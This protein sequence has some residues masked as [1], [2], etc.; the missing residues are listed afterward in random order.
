MWNF[1][2]WAIHDPQRTDPQA[3]PAYVSEVLPRFH[4]C[5]RYLDI[6]DTVIDLYVKRSIS[7]QLLTAEQPFQLR[8]DNGA[9]L[10][11]ILLEL[12]EGDLNVFFWWT[13]TFANEYAYSIQLFDGAGQKTRQV[14]DVIGGSALISRSIDVSDLPAGEYTAQLIV[15]DYA[16]GVSQPGIIVASATPFERSLAIG[17]VLINE[18]SSL[19]AG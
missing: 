7:C 1:P 13:K 6:E 19:S 18:Q 15:Y 4:S 3:M 5:G 16:T 14:D 10:E 2:I 8:Y 12:N 11:N 17:Q 9:E